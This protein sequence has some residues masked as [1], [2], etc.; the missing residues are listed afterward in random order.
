MP[1]H[2]RGIYFRSRRG[3]HREV[4]AWSRYS[5]ARD[6]HMLACC[7]GG[8]TRAQANYVKRRSLREEVS[9]HGIVAIMNLIQD[10][11]SRLSTDEILE[12]QHMECESALFQVSEGTNDEKPY[13]WS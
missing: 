7:A 6:K 12:A 3:S 1:E 5:D 13:S 11:L 10:D 2:R 8:K 4:S 9:R